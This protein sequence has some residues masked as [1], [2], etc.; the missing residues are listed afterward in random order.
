MTA[1]VG[2]CSLAV[3]MAILR[4]LSGENLVMRALASVVRTS[5]SNS[6]NTQEG[7]DEPPDVT[8]A[9]PANNANGSGG[10]DSS[11][12]DISDVE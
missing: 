8:T 4:P 9:G 12:V 11:D 10:G 5:S 7:R 2:T 3:N 1:V 6:E